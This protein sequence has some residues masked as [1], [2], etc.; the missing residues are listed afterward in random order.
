LFLAVPGVKGFWASTPRQS[1]GILIG[2]VQVFWESIRPFF[3]WSYSSALG[4]WI[5]ESV[6]VFG[7]LEVFHLLGLTVLM[8]TILVLS[9]RLSGLVMTKQP[10]AEL[11]RQMSPWTSIGLTMMAL[12]GALMFSSGAIKYYNSQPFRFKMVLLL[13]AL[14]F[15]FTFF[16]RVSCADEKCFSP[17]AG[18]VVAGV[19]LLL[20]LGVGAAGRA[21]AFF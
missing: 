16:R 3:E 14:L 4:V 17:L 9:L 20:W 8:G 11:A 19:A 2:N 1:R 21:I 10:V 12:S 7:L 15:H 5:R 6:W 18:K 13:A